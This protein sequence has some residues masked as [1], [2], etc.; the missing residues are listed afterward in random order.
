LVKKFKEQK[1]FEDRLNRVK[2]SLD[3]SRNAYKDELDSEWKGAN[4]LKELQA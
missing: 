3:R 4:V 1:D 2:S